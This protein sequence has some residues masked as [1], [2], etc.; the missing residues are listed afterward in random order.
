MRGAAYLTFISTRPLHQFTFIVC[1]TAVI[2]LLDNFIGL[3]VRSC[4]I[5]VPMELPYRIR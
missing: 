2:Y 1:V 3:F 4:E 5:P